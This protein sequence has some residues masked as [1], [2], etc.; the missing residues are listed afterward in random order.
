MDVLVCVK[1]VPATGGT[2]PLTPDGTDVDT[3]NLGFTIG[4]HEECAVEEAA[5]I[6]EHHGGSAT[7]LTVGPPQADEQ[8]RYAMSMGIQHGVRV[9][10]QEGETAPEATA[11][12][13]VQAVRT[14]E[15]E[16]RRFDLMLFGTESADAGNA[17]VGIRVAH[18]LA[19]P[20]VGG[21]K[22]IELHPEDATAR[23]RR[24]LPEG[25]E[26]YEVPLPAAVGVRE[27]IN[28][29]RYPPVTGRLRAKRAQIRTIEPELEPGGLRRLR[30]RPPPE[31]AQD[32]VVL[33]HGAEAAK[34]VVDKL[35]ELGMV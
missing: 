17:Q 2:I 23:L 1:R 3:R 9:G 14:L 22:G 29:P 25:I 31:A 12:A 16:H 19:R 18:S 10:T 13:I 28:L 5:Q 11:A 30:L 32:P 20:I 7:V 27:G 21:I 34:P 24:E 4:P 8:L 35:T 6:V 33:G 26:V 15:S